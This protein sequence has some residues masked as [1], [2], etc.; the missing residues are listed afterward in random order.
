MAHLADGNRKGALDMMDFQLKAQKPLKE[1]VYLELKHKI[2]TGEIESQTRLMEIDLAEKMN[3]SRTPIREAIHRLADDGLVKLEARKGA[4][5]ANISIKDML[6]VFEVREDMEGFTAYLATQRITDEQ[7]FKLD[8]IA[9]RYEAATKRNDK[10][11]VI[12]LDEE[13]HNFIVA[14]CN[15]ETLAE[16]VK[17]V[18]ELSLRFRY[19]Y[20]D[21]F[22][23]YEG[24]AEQHNR[25]AEAIVS[26]DADKARKEADEHVKTLK[27][28]V[29]ELG[30]KI[31]SGDGA[32]IEV[33]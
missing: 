23:L 5:V 12:E 32:N 10:E 4:Y 20:Y 26:G 14:C 22:S 30:E 15:N 6:D 9:K 16:L 21:D 19:L 1:L 27:T 17:Y 8:E 25:I 13:F 28:F 33:E 18:Q 24:T 31:E 29:I 7:K 3:V 11:A 2:L